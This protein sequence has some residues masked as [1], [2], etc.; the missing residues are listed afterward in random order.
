MCKHISKN[1]PNANKDLSVYLKIN[2]IDSMILK[3]VDEC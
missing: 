1:V 2:K 3:P